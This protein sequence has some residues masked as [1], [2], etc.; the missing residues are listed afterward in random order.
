[1]RLKFT[2]KSVGAIPPPSTGYVLW[3]DSEL[4]GFGVRVTAHGTRS[5]IA[6]K[7]LH[8]RT[9]RVSL[10]RWPVVPVAV[11]R[12]RARKH[13]V[14]IAAQV[15]PGV[16]LA[17]AELE[18]ITL[19][20]AFRDYVLLK[21]RSKDG[22]ALKARTQGDM[23]RCCSTV[24]RG[25]A[26]RPLISLTRGMIEQRYQEECQRSVAQA[27][28]G[29]KYLRA[30]FNF[31]LE[32]KVGPDG[33]PL[34]VD[35]PV[36]V[37]R[38]QWHSIARRKRV[39]NAEDL[40]QWLP[41]V[42]GLGSVP[43]R[44]VGTGWSLPKLRHGEV[45]RDFFL[46][47]AL[48]GCR[49][50]EARKL[51]VEDVDLVHQQITFRDTKN[52]LDHTLPLTPY[53]RA[54]LQRRVKQV[55]S[56]LVF[57]SPYDGRPLSNCRAVVRRVRKLSTVQ[58]TLQDLRRLAATAMER[59]RV[60]V[61][62]IKAVLNHVSGNDVT[63]GY[64]QVDRDMKLAALQNIEQFVLASGHGGV[65]EGDGLSVGASKNFDHLIHIQGTWQVEESGG[66]LLGKLL[67]PSFE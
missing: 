38:H 1:M 31:T 60:P 36:N 6:E 44:E 23:I 45:Y 3:W 17:R 41:V 25:W 27:N 39:M 51:L 28:A 29:M 2:G 14:Q 56:D 40:R 21:R 11:A 37:L 53:L 64:V 48:T 55:K 18:A 52:R 12:K 13:L 19:E 49:P 10:G 20:Q 5:F 67:P 58:F 65:W 46:V 34:V 47:L 35:N 32:R 26:P 33:R 54:L 57:S 66:F 24:L 8:G 16:D 50:D 42:L 7:R 43:V 63:A 61:Y 4:M 22:K 15:D 9:R 30:V 62:T 59:S